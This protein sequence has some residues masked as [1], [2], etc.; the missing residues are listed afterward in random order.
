MMDLS[1][2]QSLKKILLI[3]QENK[4]LGVFYEN[5]LTSTYHENVCYVYT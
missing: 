4:Y 3:A 2:F 5:I 1:S